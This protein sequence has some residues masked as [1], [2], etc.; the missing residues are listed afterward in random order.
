MGWIYH[1]KFRKRRN[2]TATPSAAFE[3]GPANV[4]LSS[5]VMHHM[6]TSLYL[7]VMDGL[8]EMQNPFQMIL[9]A[10]NANGKSEDEWTDIQSGGRI[11]RWV[12]VKSFRLGSNASSSKR[13]KLKNYLQKINTS[14]IISLCRPRELAATNEGRALRHTW[15]RFAFD[16]FVIDP[17]ISAY[18]FDSVSAESVRP[19]AGVRH[20]I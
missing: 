5:Y 12:S 11:G 17:T 4:R 15:A 16:S 3:S 1:L 14:E 2:E 9:S 18:H 13:Q 19:S 7:L 6:S 10:A 8:F 20:P